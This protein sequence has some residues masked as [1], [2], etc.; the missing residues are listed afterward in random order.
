M[1][2][3][4]LSNKR[5]VTARAVQISDDPIIIKPSISVG[6]APATLGT[7]YAGTRLDRVVSRCCTLS[8]SEILLG[9]LGSFGPADLEASPRISA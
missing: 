7:H 8:G 1:I 6:K 5:V 3:I 2:I 4:T 9:E